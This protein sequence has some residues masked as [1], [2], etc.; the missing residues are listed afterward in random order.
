MNSRRKFLRNALQA[1][2]AGATLGRFGVLNAF[3][4]QTAATSSYKALVCVFLYGG[5]DSNNLIVPVA[6]SGSNYSAYASIRQNLA[7]AAPSTSAPAGTALLPIG[8]GADTYGLHPQLAALQGLWNTKRLAVVANVGTLVA[9]TTRAQFLSPPTTVT[10]PN[11]LFS[12]ADQV[13]GMQTATPLGFATN[14]WGGRLADVIGQLGLNPISATFPA[15]ISVT[16][17]SLFGTGAATHPA[18]VPPGA[19]IG[20]QGY[21]T[22]QAAAD[23][24][25]ALKSILSQE[26]LQTSS[27]AALIREAASITQNGI[28]DSDK[29]N[30]ALK[31]AKGIGTAFPTTNIGQQLLEVAKLIQVRDAL[32]MNRQIFFCSLGGFDTHSTQLTDQGNLFSQLNAALAAFEQSLDAELSDVA[33]GVTLFT[34]SDFNRTTQPNSNGGSDHAWGSHHLV[35]GPGVQGGKLYG[36]FPTIALNSTDDAGGEGRWIPTTAVDQYGATLAQWFG[37]PKSNLATVFPNLVN[38]QIA[39]SKLPPTYPV[40]ADPTNVGFM[41]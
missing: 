27:G 10:L 26:L 31:G 2:A 23:R 5:N 34:E 12:H 35:L 20:L 21:D 9:P 13:A 36:K 41:G 17:T 7:L 29:L 30:L 18:A 1:G 15:L 28:N 24:L 19:A 16:G 33:G 38:F 4:S 40:Y 37:V 8:F 3:A 14:G 32:G 22:S 6:T 11:N 25:F 39:A